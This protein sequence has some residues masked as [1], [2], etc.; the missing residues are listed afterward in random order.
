MQD[1]QL[2]V[3]ER[4]HGIPR[5]YLRH[6]VLERHLAVAGETRESHRE[7]LH[8]RRVHHVAEIDGADD[9]VAAGLGAQQVVGVPVAVHDLRTQA[10]QSWQDL[11]LVARIEVRAQR[12]G[13][14]GHPGLDAGLQKQRPLDVPG[15]E[16]ARVRVE[17]PLQ[18][19]REL[20]L[21]RGGMA[22]RVDP[23]R[24]ALRK[25]RSRKPAQQPHHVALAVLGR[26]PLAVI[27][28]RGR[29]DTRH[30]QVGGVLLEV[31][32]S[33]DLE[34]DRALAFAGGG[35]LEDVTRAV[36]GR[37]PMVLVALAV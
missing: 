2:L 33:R 7:V 6:G 8:Q 28:F 1:L 14:I 36:R 19:A 25:R 10:G 24:L 31:A 11:A 15:H 23:E 12:L 27:A 22:Q 5:L 34:I 37:E 13:V 26:N 18:P 35:D 3:R 4:Q 20:R 21:E 17:Q 32:Q 30:R 29:D 9:L 16:V